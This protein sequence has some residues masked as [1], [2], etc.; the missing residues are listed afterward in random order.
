MKHTDP[1]SRNPLSLDEIEHG[2]AEALA[3]PNDALPV[4]DPSDRES[5]LGLLHRYLALDTDVPLFCLPP[6]GYYVLRRPGATED[7]F[8]DIFRVRAEDLNNFRWWTLIAE[9]PLENPRHWA[10]HRA[11]T[12]SEALELS[13]HR[14]R[15][16]LEEPRHA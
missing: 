5:L 15:Y 4:Y 10:L 16:H 3:P 9:P 2:L 7:T 11:R 6:A 12:P 13:Q 14:L 8:P 1:A